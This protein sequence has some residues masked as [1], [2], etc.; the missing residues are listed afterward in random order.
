VA[1]RQQAAACLRR[2]PLGRRHD[3]QMAES[4]ATQFLHGD[5][6]VD[7]PACE[8]LIWVTWAEVVV[9]TAVTCSCCRTRIWLGDADGSM[10]NAGQIIE[11]QIEQALK[12][13]WQ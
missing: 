2:R 10:Q 7:C 6:E 8:Y 9:R 4:L 5:L 11:Q 12:G 3:W 1:T 13:L